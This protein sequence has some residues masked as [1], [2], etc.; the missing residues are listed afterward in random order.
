MTKIYLGIVHGILASITTVELPL[1]HH[2]G[3]QE[4]MTADIPAAFSGRRFPATTAIEPLSTAET[5]T[6]VRLT[7][8][9]GVTHQLRVHAA[10]IGHPLV[11]DL[12]YGNPATRDRMKKPA[13]CCSMPISCSF[14]RPHLHR[15]HRVAGKLTGDK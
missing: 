3:R 11:G 6:T 2:P 15:P 10:A 13:A 1:I 7:M 14:R 5:T 9:T 12:L 8:T 4:R